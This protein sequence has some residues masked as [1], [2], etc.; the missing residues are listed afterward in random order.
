MKNQTE[1]AS[2]DINQLLDIEI[3]KHDT[4]L[5]GSSGKGKDYEDGFVAGL[6]HAKENLGVAAQ[7]IS[8]QT[9]NQQE[10]K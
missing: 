10:T 6:K 7:L 8:L 1:I 5:R 4:E 9:S 2:Q 3:A